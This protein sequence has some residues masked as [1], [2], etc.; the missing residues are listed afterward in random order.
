[1]RT[2]Y[3]MFQRPGGY[4]SNDMVFQSPDRIRQFTLRL[5]KRWFGGLHPS[6]EW[7]K[8]GFM[9]EAWDKRKNRITVEQVN[10][11]Y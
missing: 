9:A 2:Y 4:M 11:D 10:N 1:M 6:G 5:F 8:N 3:V 7:H